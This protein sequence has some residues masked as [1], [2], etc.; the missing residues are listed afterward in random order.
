[1]NKCKG[2]LKYC[3]EYNDV[4]N[5]SFSGARMYT[6]QWEPGRFQSVSYV[7]NTAGMCTFF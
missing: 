7:R 3:K 1:M 2:V 4:P 6:W 5:L